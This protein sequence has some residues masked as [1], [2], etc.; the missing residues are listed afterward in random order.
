[1]TLEQY[2]GD[3]WSVMDHQELNA[4]LNRCALLYKQKKCTPTFKEIFRAFRFCTRKNCK[5]IVLGMDPYT[6]EGVATG[7]AFANSKQQQELSPS[8]NIIKN[9]LIPLDIPNNLCIFDQTLESIAEQGVLWLNTALT[10][11]VNGKPGVHALEWFNFT[12]TFLQK[13]GEVETGIVY[14]LLGSQARQFKR[15]INAS[16]NDILEC[17][18]PSYYARTDTP[19]PHIFAPINK[20][21]YNRYGQTIKWYNKL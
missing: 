7:L 4:T 12:R 6:Q 9:C 10:T 19:M 3:W 15:Y 14:V 5:V 2:L 1:M 17:G 18:H 11:E 16:C 21:L 20:I 13:F 8:L